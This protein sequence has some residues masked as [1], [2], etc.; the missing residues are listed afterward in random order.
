MNCVSPEQVKYH[1]TRIVSELFDSEAYRTYLADPE[2][3]T[4]EFNGG[5]QRTYANELS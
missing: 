5:G 4:L 1:L 2:R 3:F